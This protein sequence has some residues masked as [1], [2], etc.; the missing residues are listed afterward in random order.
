MVQGVQFFACGGPV[1]HQNFLNRL[2]SPWSCLCTF[3]ENLLT[4][5]VKI[6]LWT[7]NYTPYSITCLSLCQCHTAVWQVL[8]WESMGSPFFFFFKII[9]SILGPLH[10]H[11]KFRIN[12]SISFFLSFF[13]DEPCQILAPGIKPRPSTVRGQSPNHWTFRKSP[14]CQFL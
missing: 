10:F 8:K 7:F 13:L 1:V 12:L 5:K 4:I 3:I 6:C 11:M 9:L 2:V 14:T